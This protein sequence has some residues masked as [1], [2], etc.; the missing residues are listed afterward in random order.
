MQ[1][2]YSAKTTISKIIFSSPIAFFLG[3]GV[4]VATDI[5][6]PSYFKNIPAYFPYFIAA[7]LVGY[8][9]VFLASSYISTTKSKPRAVFFMLLFMAMEGLFS[10]LAVSTYY[11]SQEIPILRI[12]SGLCLPLVF[13]L[14]YFL[15]IIEAEPIVKNVKELIDEADLF[16]NFD[17]LERSK[18]DF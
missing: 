8:L 4:F 17:E 1:W 13:S 12:V 16:K 11:G 15:K 9:A 6:Q 7:M 3:V 14:F 18:P 10:V 5:L 2:K